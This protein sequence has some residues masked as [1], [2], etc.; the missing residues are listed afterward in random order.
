MSEANREGESGGHV[1][2]PAD[3]DRGRMKNHNGM[4]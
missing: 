1:E 2:V 3:G 4:S